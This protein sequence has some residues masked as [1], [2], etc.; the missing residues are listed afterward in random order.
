MI[1]LYLKLLS[2]YQKSL[3]ELA[4]KKRMALI[5]APTG[6]GKTVVLAG[7]PRR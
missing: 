4:L 1:S 2:G 7:I 3:I 6:A 5:K